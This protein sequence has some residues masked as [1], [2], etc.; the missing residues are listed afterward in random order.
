M[1]I[2]KKSAKLITGITVWQTCCKRLYKNFTIDKK[3]KYTTNGKNV[4]GI[5]NMLT[6]ITIVTIKQGNANLQKGED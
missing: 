1:N 4:T 6:M 3:Y 5:P 2:K